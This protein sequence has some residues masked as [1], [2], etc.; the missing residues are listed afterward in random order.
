MKSLFRF[1]S[2][3]DAILHILKK[4]SQREVFEALLGYTAR[5][6]LKKELKGIFKACEQSF[7]NNFSRGF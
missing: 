3:P 2:F 7:S 6:H 5:H 4:E 1:R